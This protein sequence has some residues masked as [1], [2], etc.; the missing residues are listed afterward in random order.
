MIVQQ[1]MEHAYRVPVKLESLFPKPE[2]APAR[3]LMQTITLGGES[4]Q[5]VQNKFKKGSGK[6][7]ICIQKYDIEH[8]YLYTQ[9]SLHRLISFGVLGFWGLQKLRK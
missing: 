7:K 5:S 4:I 2:E 3:Q 1:L 9:H 6:I 8:Y